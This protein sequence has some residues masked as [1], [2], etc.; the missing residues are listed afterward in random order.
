MAAAVVV[1]VVAASGVVVV[2]SM[3]VK[4]TRYRCRRRLI[5]YSA[6][7]VVTC[8][9]ACSCYCYHHGRATENVAVSWESA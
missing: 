4:M 1:V 9:A 8:F 2:V 7:V 6:I 3:Q 5:R